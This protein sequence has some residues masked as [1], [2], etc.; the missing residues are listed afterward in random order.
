MEH[1]NL[2]SSRRFWRSCSGKGGRGPS[3]ALPER[4]VAQIADL[5]LRGDFMCG[6]MPGL[7]YVRS[8]R[9][10]DVAITRSNLQ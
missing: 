10:R 1:R 2:V 4:T 5:L 7:V 8:E 6:H 9:G 3:R